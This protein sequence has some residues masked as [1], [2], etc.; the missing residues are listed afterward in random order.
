MGSD[1]KEIMKPKYPYVKR[2]RGVVFIVCSLVIAITIVLL[3]G[4]FNSGSKKFPEGRESLAGFCHSVTKWEEVAARSCARGNKRLFDAVLVSTG[5]VGTT[6][7]IENLH[8]DWRMNSIVDDDGLKHRPFYV[9]T[10]VLQG[11]VLNDSSVECATPFFLYAFGDIAGSIFSLYRRPG[12]AEAQNFK[13]HEYAIPESC[14]PETVDEYV[15]AKVDYLNLENHFNSYIHGGIC[16]S[17]VPVYFLRIQRDPEPQVLNVLKRVMEEPKQIFAST[18]QTLHIKPS[19]YETDSE[20]S[21]KYKEL[22]SVYE[23]LQKQFDDLGYL[24]VAFNGKITRLV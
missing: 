12:F 15:K 9:T 7:M 19:H 22:R 10:K 23:R 5:G 17:S 6:S 24:S 16:S 11:M 18:I 14:F 1:P 4:I 3:Y 21:E 8:T 2:K 20:T 13:T